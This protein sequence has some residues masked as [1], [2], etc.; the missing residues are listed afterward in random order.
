MA[1]MKLMKELMETIRQKENGPQP[2]DTTA[3]VVRVDGG[4]AWVSI[5]GGEG[6]TPVQMSINA[7]PGDTVRVRVAGGQ[8]WTVG[9]DTAPPTDDRAAEAAQETAN[10]ALEDAQR[11]A[12][13]ADAAEVSAAAAQESAS[14][15]AASAAQAIEDA[16]EASTAAATAQTSANNAATAASAAQ[17]SADAASNSLKSVV[18]G[19]TTVEKAVSVMQ[20]ALEA[21]VDYDAA[22]DTTQEYFWHDAN[23]AHVLGAT[24]GYRNDV[25]STGMK[26]VEVATEDSVAEFG[27]SGAQIGKTDES[28]IEMDYHSMQLIDKDSNTYFHVSDLRDKNDNNKA[29]MT[30][31]FQG[32]GNTRSFQVALDVSDEVSAVDGND[33]TNTA[34]RSGR[35]YTFATIPANRS[36]I[37]I[38][39]KTTSQYAKAVTFGSRYSEVIGGFSLSEG[40]GTN[41]MGFCTHAE[42]NQT[43]A[44]GK[45]SHAEGWAGSAR[46]DASHAEGVANEAI[47]V[48]S[49]A[50]GANTSAIGQMSH[51]EGYHSEAMG[52]GSHSEGYRTFAIGDYSHAQNYET[53]AASDY[54]TA[55]GKYNV[56]D[57]TSAVMIG[58]GT[59]S[60]R[61]NALTVGW[62]G[63]VFLAL[64]TSA[65]SGTTDGDLYTAITAL[66]WAADVIAS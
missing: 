12:E 50:E 9:N 14:T 15:A 30:E 41:A 61:S 16:E 62:D 13:A 11:A 52:E 58:N 51:A 10:T 3:E 20:T 46:G 59:S 1:D 48:G 24:S 65:S 7:R 25:A 29:T 40:M 55:L 22:N 6:E 35:T 27:A 43:S 33:S 47:G 5:P 60:A 17:A 2:Y 18:Q 64:D 66:G 28:H 39:Y 8:A 53:S 57:S 26:V 21:I 49:H 45:N 44:Y 54:Q 23:G 56:S 42:G 36:L 19:A 38:V 31:M 32:D 37:T 63:N 4:T 34:T